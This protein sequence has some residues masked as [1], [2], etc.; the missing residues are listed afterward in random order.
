MHCEGR[1]GWRQERN[2]KAR[3]KRKKKAVTKTAPRKKTAAAKKTK[4]IRKKTAKKPPHR[5]LSKKPTAKAAVKPQPV[6]APAKPE[7][8]RPAAQPAPP[9]ERIGVV[10]H[11]FGRLSVATLRLE[12]GTLRVGDIIRIRGHTTDFTTKGRV[13]RSQSFG[14]DR[15]GPERRFRP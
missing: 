8:A 3:Q 1:L 2:P 4:T 12:T 15:G 13:P 5:V 6:T 9:E 10:T 11:Y 14:G 7:V